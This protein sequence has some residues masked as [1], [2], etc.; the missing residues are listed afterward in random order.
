M[1]STSV[2]V[3]LEAGANLYQTVLLTPVV[4]GIWLLWAHR[5][6]GS[7]ACVVAPELSTVSVKEPPAP[8]VTVVALAKLSLAGAATA[9]IK[10]GKVTV[11][12]V[13]VVQPRGGGFWT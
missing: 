9:M 10:V 2:I 3:P 13:T 4:K 8:G 5:G 7:V 12:V 6:T 11:C 1:V